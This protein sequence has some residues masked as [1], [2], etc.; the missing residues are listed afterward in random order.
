ML[1]GFGSASCSELVNVAGNATT[2]VADF[3]NLVAGGNVKLDISDKDALLKLVVASSDVCFDLLTSD[4]ILHTQVLFATESHTTIES[5]FSVALNFAASC[6][7][8]E[9]IAVEAV[10]AVIN[11][12]RAV[13]VQPTTRFRV[14]AGVLGHL[15]TTTQIDC[16][17]TLLTQLLAFAEK[18]MM[19][20]PARLCHMEESFYDLAEDIESWSIPELSRRKLNH[21]LASTLQ[22]LTPTAL[23]KAQEC[24]IRY[25][26]SFRAGD[27]GILSSMPIAITALTTALSAPLVSIKARHD[28]LVLPAIT[29]LDTTAMKPLLGLWRAVTAANF[30]VYDAY[31]KENP[32]TLATSCVDSEKLEMHVKLLSLCE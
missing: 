7:I 25:L 26:A 2:K 18:T 13:S 11:S 14:A 4:W 28:L 32:N 6:F 30:D 21:S 12:P 29:A 16:K 20:Q 17:V 23:N 1:G 9:A 27:P 8:E 5:I 3:I 15:N 24:R 19:S 10:Q 31:V 22:T